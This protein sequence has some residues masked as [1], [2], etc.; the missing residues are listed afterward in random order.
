MFYHV[1]IACYHTSLGMIH[2]TTCHT[3]QRNGVVERKHRHILDMTRTLMLE[4]MIPDYLWADAVLTSTYLINY[5]PSS[6]LGGEIP[7][8]RLHPQGDQ[9]PLPPRVFGCMAFVQDYTPS[10]SK[11]APRVL[12]RVFVGYAKTQKGYWIYLP[13]EQKYMVSAD[14]TFHEE[15]PYFSTS[16]SFSSFMPIPDNMLFIHKISLLLMQF[17]ALIIPN[18]CMLSYFKYIS[19]ILYH[20]M[21]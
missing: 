1:K 5:L 6:P 7:L 15:T 11:L 8:R 13:R 2:Q 21:S 3:S 19:I 9:F 14:V 16:S 12:K 18:I 20:F 10:K 4:M 17:K